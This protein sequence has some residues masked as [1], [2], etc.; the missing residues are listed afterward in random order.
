MESSG[1]KSEVG[2]AAAES[3]VLSTISQRKPQCVLL[4]TC[5]VKIRNDT[6]VTR[7]RLLLDN[8]SM[9][10]LVD[11]DIACKL[12][13]PVIR[14]ESLSVFI[15]GNKSPIKKT[16]DVVK[17]ELGNRKTGFQC[18]NRGCRDRADF[19]SDLPPS[20]LKVEIVKKISGGFPTC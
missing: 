18:G 20:N 16:F 12:K 5:D 4:Q 14:R 2:G 13:L 9:R 7:A 8:G 19:G 3:L 6:E 1:T 17:M 10:S 15:F 11:R